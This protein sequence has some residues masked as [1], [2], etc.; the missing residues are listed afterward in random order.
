MHQ[1]NIFSMEDLSRERHEMACQYPTPRGIIKNHPCLTPLCTS[2]LPHCCVS[3]ECHEFA[4]QFPCAH[5][6]LD[7]LSSTLSL[8]KLCLKVL[9]NEHSKRCLAF[10]G[11]C[12]N[13]SEVGERDSETMPS[14]TVLES[15]GT[16][17]QS[18]HSRKCHESTCRVLNPE[19]DDAPVLP[20]T[21]LCI[22]ALSNKPRK[23]CRV[24]ACQFPSPRD[25]MECNNNTLSSTVMEPRD[26]ET[27]SSDIVPESH[28]IACQFPS[29]L[30]DAL[31]LAMLLPYGKTEQS[32]N[33]RN[34][35]LDSAQLPNTRNAS[36]NYSSGRR[37]NSSAFL[38]LKISNVANN[39][40]YPILERQRRMLGILNQNNTPV[41]GVGPDLA[42]THASHFLSGEDE[43]DNDFNLRLHD[44]L[45]RH[46]RFATVLF[47]DD[48]FVENKFPGNENN[49]S[50][51]S[52]MVPDIY[53][54]EKADETKQ[55]LNELLRK[56]QKFAAV[57]FSAE[58]N[59]QIENAWETDTHGEYMEEENIMG[60]T[61]ESEYN[62]VAPNRYRRV[63]FFDEN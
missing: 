39:R 13:P 45:Q 51:G 37:L 17:I 22:K 20:L 19:L 18:D 1:N 63:R 31:T 34:E 48:Q 11:Q 52:K 27:V 8:T 42:P 59:I 5:S 3:K 33:L 25:G 15:H 24:I 14:S 56:H 58:N 2:T 12:L 28:K 6:I 21:Q 43:V 7:N 62:F 55:H 44:L 16:N 36:E 60:R 54:V 32:K 38:P 61:N 26:T 35:C 29:R 10:A 50:A 41:D 57:L 49:S 46:Q 9:S 23:E 40:L 47:D 53:K 30:S 4:G